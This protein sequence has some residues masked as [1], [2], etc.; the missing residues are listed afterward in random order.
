[1]PFVRP[2]DLRDS[3]YWR[4]TRR[5]LVLFGAAWILAAGIAWIVLSE[6]ATQRAQD[7]MH[8]Y[9]MDLAEQAENKPFQILVDRIATN[10]R[11][12]ESE[13][14]FVALLAND[15]TLVAGRN[16][17]TDADYLT[18]QIDEPWGR[19]R[20]GKAYEDIEEPVVEAMMVFLGG[21]F[22]ILVIAAGGGL[23]L[24]RKSTSLNSS[25]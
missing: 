19:A 13:D 8:L 17:D 14:G 16:P 9:L 5:L 24:D 12:T 10:S 23:L 15:G 25:H 3:G 4:L 6:A 1:M 20:V 22:A 2:A 21:G 11:E 7:E 18:R